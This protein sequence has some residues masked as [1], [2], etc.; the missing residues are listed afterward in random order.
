MSELLT[1][2]ELQTLLGVDRKTVYRMLKEERLP[3]VRVGGQWRFPRQ[4]IQHWLHTPETP[5]PEVP[6]L[7]NDD[8]TDVLPLDCFA[9][10]QDVFAEAMGVGIVTTDLE[11][12]PL[13]QMSNP[14][15]FCQLLLATPEGRK[16]CQASWRRLGVSAAPT[17]IE[18]CHAG[19]AYARGKIQV[20]DEFVAMVFAGQ[21]LTTAAARK[22]VNATLRDLAHACEIPETKLRAA[23]NQL[24]VVEPTHAD[25]ILRMLTQVAETFSQIGRRRLDLLLRLR[26]VAQIAAI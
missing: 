6:R 18:T 22:R 7:V 5:T 4:A 20:E 13:T 19:L 14:R 21:I 26:R 2:K 25:K 10:I 11:G 8:N 9:A 17:Q 1:T 3:A 24:C 15:A 23:A 12:N 16:R